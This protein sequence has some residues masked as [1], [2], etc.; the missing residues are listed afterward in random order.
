[1]KRIKEYLKGVGLLVIVT[2]L[3]FHWSRPMNKRSKRTAWF[4][5]LLVLAVVVTCYEGVM[6]A[7]A[8]RSDGVFETSTGDTV[9]V[10]RWP[11]QLADSLYGVTSCRSYDKKVLIQWNVKLKNDTVTINRVLDHEYVHLAQ[12]LREGSCAKWSAWAKA[13]PVRVEA[14]AQCP[15]FLNGLSR[16][17]TFEARFERRTRLAYVIQKYDKKKSH[18]FGDILKMID[19]C[20]VNPLFQPP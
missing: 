7:Q 14:E 5:V 4:S 20:S 2:L 8:R 9:W 3:T 19:E 18:S 12:I 11:G 15:L 6:S 13:N 17:S 16:D 1:M 10:D